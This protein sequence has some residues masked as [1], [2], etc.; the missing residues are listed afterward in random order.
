[1]RSPPTLPPPQNLERGPGVIQGSGY[2][3]G[4]SHR[5]VSVATGLIDPINRCFG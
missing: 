2:P 4:L 3:M 5:G 1:M